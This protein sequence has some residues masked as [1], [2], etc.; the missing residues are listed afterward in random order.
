MKKKEFLLI[1]GII[2]FGII[3]SFFRNNDMGFYSGCSRSPRSLLSKSHPVDFP[4]EEIKLSDSG[5]TKIEINNPAGDIKV[6][7]SKDGSASIRPVIRVYHK[8][9]EKAGSIADGVT[10]TSRKSGDKIVIGVDTEGKFL[11]R[12]IRVSLTC[13][14]PAG[15]ELEVKNRHG[16]IDIQDISGDI[17]IDQK[18][19]D[20]FVKNVGS[21]VKAKNYKGL[22]R[23]YDIKDQI[24]LA[25]Q[26][27][28]IK[29]KNVSSI[30]LSKCSKADVTISDISAETEIL[31]SVLS[32]IEIENAHYIFIESRHTGI[33]LKNITGG[34]RIKNSH[35]KISMEDITGDLDISARQC[36]IVMDH[37]VSDNLVVK[38]SYNDI[39]ISGYSG[40]FL[41]I[42][43]EYGRLD[44]SVDNVEEKINIKTR[45]GDVNLEY[46]A[47][48]K[49]SFNIT[50]D[51][52]KIINRTSSQFTVLEE[53][54][55]RILN[56]AEQKPDTIIDTLYGD[57]KLEN[58]RK[59]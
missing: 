7:Q 45:H 14:I 2:A 5:I 23:L 6:E 31:E 29:I 52:G 50:A 11:Y 55:K 26:D 34:I 25:S 28:R 42:L 10:V 51:N 24:D 56:T 12:R 13:L 57:V 4:R 32:N 54:Q 9:K 16:D 36:H 18:Y 41:D 3:Y 1:I 58:S 43:Q 53:R 37:V 40:R 19:G 49:P 17:S 27:S 39:E 22:V 33:K 47:S 21:R 48:M 35:A 44:L 20:L 8:D 15:I 38:N 46:P 30:I 59:Q